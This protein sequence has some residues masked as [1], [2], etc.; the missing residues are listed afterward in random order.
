[1]DSES[2]PAPLELHPMFGGGSV[3]SWL[4]HPP[5]SDL[6]RSEEFVE[7]SSPQL[8]AWLTA[9]VRFTRPDGSVI[10]DQ[11]GRKPARLVELERWARR[12][13]DPSLAR[14]VGWWRPSSP[15]NAEV[16]W[17]APPLPTAT[18]LDRPLAIL[19]PDWTARG[20]W[21][22]VDHQSPGTRTIIEVAGRG[23]KWLGPDWTSPHLDA[24]VTPARAIY[25]TTGPYADAYEWSFQVG[26]TRVTRTAVLIRG[27]SLALL[28]QTEEGVGPGVGEVR[29]SLPPGITA[30]PDSTLRTLILASGRGKPVARLI[31]LGLPESAYTTERGSLEVD[32]NEV[33]LRHRSAG[34]NRCQA[35]LVSWHKKPPRGWRTLTVAEKSTAC[36][37]ETAFAARVGWG[38][39]QNGLLIYKSLGPSGLR[40]VLGHQTRARLLVA[41]F[42][43]TGEVHPWVKAIDKP[44]IVNQT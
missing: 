44:K 22:A 12:V 18:W 43:P 24:G 7:P 26:P 17:I 16:G 28:L 6:T 19:R 36:P 25:A 35:L 14:V 21:L 5:V 33:V 13:G 37:P 41:G 10:L 40:S 8:R 38:S 1:M 34:P 3:A 39:R 27:A 42:S 20:D 9:I 30:T 11:Q 23:V 2:E 32:G 15:I 29:W 4:D 31:P